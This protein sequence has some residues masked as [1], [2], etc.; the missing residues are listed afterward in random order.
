MQILVVLP[1]YYKLIQEFKNLSG[2]PVILNTSFNL[3]GEP[4]VC[5]VKDALRTFYSSGM[6][7]LA[8][9]DFIIRKEIA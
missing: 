9:G 7:I 4:I 8:I 1:L 5:T 6:D 2:V 3:K